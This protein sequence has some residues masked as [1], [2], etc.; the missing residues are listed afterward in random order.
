MRPAL[1]PK[2]IEIERPEIVRDSRLR[3]LVWDR[4]QGI[5]TQ[6]QRF[7]K[8]WIC[9]HK[10]PLWSKG[11]DDLT[12]LQTLCRWCDRPKTSSE[13]TIRAKMDRLAQADQIHKSRRALKH[14]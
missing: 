4:D 3:R 11:A 10:N 5:C 7:D 8:K 9:E 6:C 1:K 13:T 12:N 2:R 14:T